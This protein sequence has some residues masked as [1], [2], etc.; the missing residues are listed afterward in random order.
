MDRMLMIDTTG[1]FRGVRAVLA[2][3]AVLAVAGC[4]GGT[5][6]TMIDSRADRSAIGAGLDMRDFEG[7]AGEAVQSML[8][9]PALAKP[10]GGRYVLA[11]SRI[12]NDTMQRLD[13]DLLVKKIRVDLLNS[14]RFV[15]TTAVGLDAPEDPM[16]MRTRELRASREFNQAQ[17]A[18]P[19]QMVAPD[20]SLSGK[21]IQLNRRL[22]DGSERIDYSFQLSLTDIRTGLALWEGDSPIAKL[23]GGRS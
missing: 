23:T 6:T 18:R 1:S 16:A 17:V 10:G 11:I 9:S 12:T 13:T 5:Q 8:A 15:V 20:L 4:A 3:V 21:I 14:N 19:G 22:G 2:F 7:A